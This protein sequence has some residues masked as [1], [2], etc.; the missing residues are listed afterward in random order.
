MRRIAVAVVFSLLVAPALARANDV[1]TSDDKTMD[2]I[3]TDAERNVAT[4]SPA[5]AQDDE[6]APPLKLQPKSGSLAGASVLRS[7]YASLGVLQAYDVYSTRKALRHGAVERNPFMQGAVGN[8]ALFIGLKVAMTAGPVYQAE[9]LWRNHHRIGAVA[10][11]AVSNGIMMGV[12]AHN[13]AVIRQAQASR[14][15]R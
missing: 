14:I 8:Q 5:A 4:A 12:A 6:T 13:A 11:M 7:M 10:L 2:A 9:K 3:A 1:V 15:V